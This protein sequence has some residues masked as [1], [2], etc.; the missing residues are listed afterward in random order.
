M[1]EV[2]CALLDLNTVSLVLGVSSFG[3]SS[4]DVVSGPLFL[5]LR[6]VFRRV[7]LAGRDPLLARSPGLTKAFVETFLAL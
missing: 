1:T 2:L 4:G 5:L 3:D 7:G 6:R